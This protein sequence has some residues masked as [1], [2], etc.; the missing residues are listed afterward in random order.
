MPG[1]IRWQV[2]VPENGMFETVVF[3]NEDFR[4]AKKNIPLFYE[5]RLIDPSDED[6]GISKGKLSFDDF[7]HYI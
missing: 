3:P 5:V 6:F 2:H 7:S 1:K 4:A